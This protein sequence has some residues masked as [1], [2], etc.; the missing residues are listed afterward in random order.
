[1]AVPVYTPIG[2]RLSAVILLTEFSPMMA[3]GHQVS[4]RVR[5]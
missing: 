4:G 1:M 3:V 5:R 2:Q